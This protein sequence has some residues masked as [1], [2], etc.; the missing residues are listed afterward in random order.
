M[1]KLFVGKDIGLVSLVIVGSNFIDAELRQLMLG[2]VLFL[3][4]FDDRLQYRV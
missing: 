2:F 1:L 3:N 4:L